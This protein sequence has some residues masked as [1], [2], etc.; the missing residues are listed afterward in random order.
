MGESAIVKAIS[1]GI[2]ATAIY[3][4]GGIDILIQ[5]LLIITSQG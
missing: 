3:L 5:T 1:T 2:S 4:I